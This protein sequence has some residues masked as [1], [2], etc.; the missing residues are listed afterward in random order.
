MYV[1]WLELA[2]LET[3]EQL[4]LDGVDLLPALSSEVRVERL[5]R[6]RSFLPCVMVRFG[7]ATEDSLALLPWTRELGGRDCGQ[8]FFTPM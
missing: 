1:N 6:Q 8:L 7:M 3:L 5:E 2:G 4:I